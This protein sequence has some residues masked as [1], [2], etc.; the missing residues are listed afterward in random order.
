MRRK[1]V[2]LA[3]IMTLTALVVGCAMGTPAPLAP[4]HARSVWRGSRHSQ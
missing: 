2:S 1:A 4:G 3:V